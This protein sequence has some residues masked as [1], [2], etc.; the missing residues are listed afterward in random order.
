MSVPLLDLKRQNLE[1]RDRVLELVAEAIEGSAFI[2]GSRVSEFEENFARFCGAPHAVAVNSGTDAL[3]LA[4]LALGLEPGDE[5][6]TVPFTFIATT[7]VISEVG[8]K[9]VLV[10]IDPIT[11]NL[12]PTKLEAAITPRTRGIVPVHI[13]GNPADMD[14]INA[15]AEKHGLWVL[16]DACQAHGAALGERM[17]GSL[18][19]AAAFSFYP[20]KNMGAMGEGGIITTRDEE[21]ANRAMALRNHGQSSR[22]HHEF[23]GFNARL[24]AIQAAILNE[25]LRHLPRWNSQRSA[26]A[27]RYREGLA[28]VGDLILPPVAPGATH[29]Y[30]LFTVRTSRRDDLRAFLTEKGIGTA[31]HYPVPLHMQR[32]YARLGYAEDTFPVARDCAASVLSL[33]MF[34]LITDAE[35][36]ETIAAV[37]AFFA[38]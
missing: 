34:Q 8:G 17:V 2:G 25:K 28:G 30:H 23:E 9:I 12:D 37:R 14:R 7:E 5:V 36:D 11:Y 21:V 32:A 22:Y 26:A 13:Y 27:A 35:V 15:I 38:R 20:T 33:P 16:E 18:G 6:I 19:H 4:I 3:K 10:D 31:V 1:I 24:D 29:A